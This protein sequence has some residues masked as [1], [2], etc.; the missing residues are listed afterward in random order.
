MSGRFRDNAWTRVQ[1]TLHKCIKHAQ[2]LV[3]LDVFCYVSNLNQNSIVAK[4]V[5]RIG[6]FVSA[7]ERFPSGVT[8]LGCRCFSSGVGVRAWTRSSENASPP[9]SGSWCNHE[10]DTSTACTAVIRTATSHGEER[11]V[12][13]VRAVSE[14]LQSADISWCFGKY[15]LKQ[16]LWVPWMKNFC[17]S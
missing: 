15:C 10:L 6:P 11:W 16:V 4:G 17:D 8:F 12:A 13:G 9:S 3:I 2:N 5:L 14:D 1:T 7:S